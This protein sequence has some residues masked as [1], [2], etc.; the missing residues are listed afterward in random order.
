M[1]RQFVIA[2]LLALLFGSISLSAQV[3]EIVAHG[4]YRMGDNDT[5]V[6]ARR[7]ALEEAKRNALEQAG[8]YVSIPTEDKKLQLAEDQVRRFI[9]RNGQLA[10]ETVENTMFG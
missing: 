2:G 3:R 9:A 7:L 1:K 10:G 5:K 4:E 6:N 8:T